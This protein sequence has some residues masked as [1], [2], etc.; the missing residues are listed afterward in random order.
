V[1]DGGTAASDDE[2]EARRARLDRFSA[3][4]ATAEALIELGQGPGDGTE[5]DRR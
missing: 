2:A 5:E 1:G 3:G 4:R